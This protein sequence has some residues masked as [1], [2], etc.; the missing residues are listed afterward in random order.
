MSAGASVPRLPEQPPEMLRDFLCS[1]FC[2]ALV[3]SGL[4]WPV[5]AGLALTATEQLLASFTLS[6]C[7]VFVMAW[8]VYVFNLPAESLWALPVLA[9]GGLLLRWKKLVLTLRDPAA[10]RLIQT[11]LVVTAWCL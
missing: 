1:L 10:R 11:Q 7:G 5:A 2:F 6:L 8:G 3:T 4:G 9:A